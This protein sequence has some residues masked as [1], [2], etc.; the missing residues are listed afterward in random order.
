MAGR[1][2]R[3]QRTSRSMWPAAAVLGQPA[4]QPYILY[5]LHTSKSQ[6]HTHTHM[7][8]SQV[9]TRRFARRQKL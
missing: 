7:P 4:Q 2:W 5:H 9:P 3:L 1:P 8:P 6:A